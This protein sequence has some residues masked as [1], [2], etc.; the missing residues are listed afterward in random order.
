LDLS[1]AAVEYATRQSTQERFLVG[2]IT[3]TGFEPGS[4]DIV[5]YSGVL[6]HFPTRE[7]RRRV[8]AEGFRL[9]APGGRL[10]AFDP[11]QHSPSMWL[12][13]DP[14]SPLFSSEG[15]TENEVLLSRQQLSAELSEVGFDQISVRGLSGIS[16]RYVKSANARVVLPLYNLYELCMQLSP[17]ERWLGTFVISSAVKTS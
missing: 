16:F 1:P 13:R 9:L 10:F 7:E 11:N 2:D 6:H 12:Y 15:K 17:F 8:L 5:L 14:R 4:Y 3:H